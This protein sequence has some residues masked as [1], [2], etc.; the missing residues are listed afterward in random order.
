MLFEL[1][2][3]LCLALGVAPIDPAG[4]A[5]PDFSGCTESVTIPFTRKPDFD[6]LKSM[7]V[8]VSINGSKPLSM[9]VDTGSVGVIVSE[10]DIPEVA[11]DAPEGQI[12]YSSS[13]NQLLG[14]WTPARIQ[15]LDKDNRPIS[16]AVAECPVLAAYKLNVIPGAVNQPRAAT[17]PTTGPNT[18]PTTGPT[19]KPHP[20]MFGVGFGRGKEAHPERNPFLTLKPMLAGT[21][22][23]GYTITHSGYTLGLTSENA[24]GYVFQKLTPREVSA[25]AAKVSP[26]L[27][28]YVTAPGSIIVGDK[29]ELPVLTLLDTGLTNMMIGQ[30]GLAERAEVPEGTKITVKLLGGQLSYSFTV[31]DSKNPAVPRRVTYTTPSATAPQ[32]SLNTGLRALANFDYLYDAREG[33]LGLKPTR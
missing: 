28:D 16:G 7:H 31:G 29:P 19:K 8:K 17:R 2:W 22:R 27:K 18:G 12:T 11:K 26:H 32:G 14:H 25:D 1:P 20:F 4:S 5:H 23:P 33:Y 6:D 10:D 24:A 30:P 3:V 21:M 9:E 13:G 15:F